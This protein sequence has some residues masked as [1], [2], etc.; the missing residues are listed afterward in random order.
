MYFIRRTPRTGG[1]DIMLQKYWQKTFRFRNTN[2]RW[3]VHIIIYHYYI[4]PSRH[5]VSEVERYTAMYFA[6]DNGIAFMSLR[7]TK[8]PRLAAFQNCSSRAQ[9][10]VTVRCGA[11]RFGSVNIIYFTRGYTANRLLDGKTRS[12]TTRQRQQQ[13]QKRIGRPI[14]T[15]NGYK[16]T[17]G[18]G[19]SIFP[20]I[21]IKNN[22]YKMSHF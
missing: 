21:C 8:T 17:A 7:A 1:R 5:I 2:F 19:K 22:M 11:V 4:C 12:P 9:R 20:L 6:P 15:W 3:S 14:T 10:C 16:N 18:N 13:Q